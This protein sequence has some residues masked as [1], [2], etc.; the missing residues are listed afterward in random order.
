MGQ[1]RLPQEDEAS[2]EENM[3]HKK[4][5]KP[6]IASA[7]VIIDWA[8]SLSLLQLY[9]SIIRIMVRKTRHSRVQ[10]S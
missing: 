3:K 7:V 4:L 10:R 9:V 8:I 2:S 1:E 5:Q 6:I